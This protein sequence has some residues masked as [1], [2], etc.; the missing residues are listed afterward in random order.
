M[1]ILQIIIVKTVEPIELKFFE[2]LHITAGKVYDW[3]KLKDFARK[4]GKILLFLKTHQFKL[5]KGFKMATKNWKL[6]LLMD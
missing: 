4:N 2:E 6:M 5:K 3:S 1:L